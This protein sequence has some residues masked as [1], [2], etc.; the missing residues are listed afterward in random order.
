[1]SD[2]MSAHQSN[3]DQPNR[4]VYEFGPFRLDV[5]KRLLLRE[6]Q[7]VALTQRL[8]ETLLALVE[9]SG[10]VIAKDE[11]MSKLWPDTVVEEANLTVNISALRKVLGETAGEHRYIA[12][13]PGRGYQFVARVRR[14]DEERT[15]LILEKLTSAEI[16]IEEHEDLSA[17]PTGGTGISPSTISSVA[18]ATESSP[19]AQPSRRTLKIAAACAVG[20]LLVC[21]FLYFRLAGR[22]L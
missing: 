19:V 5:A 22:V 20:L 16:I 9:N 14:A 7:T 13:I 17:E 12:T 4:P 10:R 8:F 15:R 2:T 6:G 3:A 18:S 11:L 1:M 21:A